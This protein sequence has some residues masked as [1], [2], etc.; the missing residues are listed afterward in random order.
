MNNFHGHDAKSEGHDVIEDPTLAET[1]QSGNSDAGRTNRD[2][3]ADGGSK[4]HDE[5][6]NTGEG[7][8]PKHEALD[9]VLWQVFESG[10]ETEEDAGAS[11]GEPHGLG[12]AERFGGFGADVDLLVEGVDGLDTDAVG[13]DGD[14]GGGGG[15]H[16]TQS[17]EHGG[18]LLEDF[19]AGDGISFV[20]RDVIKL[21]HLGCYYL[22]WSENYFVYIFKKS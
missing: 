11:D 3:A 17:D 18:L 22:I 15:D 14:D 6:A 9:P 19:G 1:V 10:V 7:Q 21:I 8:V 13:D 4:E 12:G 5:A 20:E 2:R 16:E